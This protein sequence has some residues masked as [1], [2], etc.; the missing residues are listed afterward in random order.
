LNKNNKQGNNN[1][2]KVREEQKSNY[3]SNI[4]AAYIQRKQSQAKRNVEHKHNRVDHHVKIWVQII[5]Q[6]FLPK[7]GAIILILELL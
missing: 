2:I 7:Y 6:A 3:G 5:L 4:Q 1:V